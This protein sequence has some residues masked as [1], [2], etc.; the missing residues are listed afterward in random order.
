MPKLTTRVNKIYIGVQPQITKQG[1]TSFFITPTYF[2]FCS[3][4][5]KMFLYP[6]YNKIGDI[7]FEFEKIVIEKNLYYNNSFK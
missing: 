7:M 4:Y 1:Q 6:A 2:H 5:C 3:F